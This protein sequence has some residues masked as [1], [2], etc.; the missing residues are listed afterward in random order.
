MQRRERAQQL[1]E[2]VPGLR[3]RQRGQGTAPRLAPHALNQVTER[4]AV[5]ELHHQR[6]LTVEIREP[7]EMHDV[8]MRQA[9]R[10]SRDRRSACRALVS[11]GP[12]V[13]RKVRGPWAKLPPTRRRGCG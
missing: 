10:I 12:R 9:R 2:I 13:Y 5:H 11:R 1:R 7:E 4:L 8:R 6:E 3:E